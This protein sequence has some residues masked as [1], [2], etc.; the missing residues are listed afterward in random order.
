M[1]FR[2]TLNRFYG[3]L[4]LGVLVFNKDYSQV[5]YSNAAY[6]DL[7]GVSEKTLGQSKH[8]AALVA[9][10]RKNRNKDS[11][12]IRFVPEDGGEILV[13]EIFLS[14]LEIAPQV[15]HLYSLIPL[16]NREKMHRTRSRESYIFD[17]IRVN[18]PNELVKFRGKI[19]SFSAT[20]F[21]L[22]AFLCKN[23]DRL[24]S[25]E[26]LLKEVWGKAAQ[27]TRTVDIY[28]GRVKKRLKEAGCKLDYIKTLHGR[29]AIFQ[30]NA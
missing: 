26:A 13:F 20:E 29:G 9:G 16:K 25:K 2:K 28:I 4:P 1:D 22:F 12:T 14:E 18:I 8:H 23:E 7:L 21:K 5:V 30:V 15:F 17:E 27:N 19:V 10:C 24:F 6:L 3:Q 11:G